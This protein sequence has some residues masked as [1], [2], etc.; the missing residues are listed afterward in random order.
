M[1]VARSRHEGGWLALEVV[2]R[3]YGLRLDSLNGDA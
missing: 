1:W 3:L 2:S